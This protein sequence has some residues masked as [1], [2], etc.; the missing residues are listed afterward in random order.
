MMTIQPSVPQS[1]KDEEERR[2]ADKE[3]ERKK[4]KQQTSMAIARQ[5]SFDRKPRDTSTGGALGI[6]GLGAQ[7]KQRATA[8]P[9]KYPSPSDTP[10]YDSL[11]DAQAGQK[12]AMSNML[13]PGFGQGYSAKPNP[14]PA[15][16][17]N[18]AGLG[19][20]SPTQPTSD[21]EIADAANPL[22][23]TT[24]DAIS[25]DQGG[26][27]YGLSITPTPDKPSA[28][29]DFAAAMQSNG[30]NTQGFDIPK[31]PKRGIQGIKEREA[32]IK[33]ASTI[34]KGARGLTATQMNILA[35]LQGDTDKIANDQY[36]AQLGAASNMAQTQARESGANAR[37]ALGEVSAAERQGQ[38]LG[39]DADKFQQ[40]A[41]LDNRRLDI[42][43]EDSDVKNYAPK[44]L[45]SALEAYD[46]AKTPEEQAAALEK[47]KAINGIDKS[48]REDWI[49]INGGQTI[50]DGLPVDN[51]PMLLN[52]RTGETRPIDA[53][54]VQL[55]MNNP[56]VAAIMNNT[57]TSYEEKMAEL[58]A[59]GVVTQ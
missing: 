37:A 27:S 28:A 42:A 55:D 11:A 7:L 31:P 50:Q 29:Q 32:L 41:A 13:S 58:D 43:Q 38:Q 16:Q 39:F 44:R 3:W 35:G 54:P 6:G 24:T 1:I 47:I 8:N 36:Q 30:V 51:P 10:K 46:A 33:Q 49:S 9:T 21:K 25:A 19:V 23:N 4:R 12:R 40:S 14:K 17:P 48:E 57:S 34:Q 20:K 56:K 22:Y 59:L 18:M 15:A 5:Q 45:N 52:K 26:K 53:A 2:K